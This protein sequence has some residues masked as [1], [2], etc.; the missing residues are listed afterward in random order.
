MPIDRSDSR[1]RPETPSADPEAPP[2]P[3]GITRRKFMTTVGAGAAATAV[4]GTLTAAP[5]E[6]RILRAGELVRVPLRVN[7]R[8]YRVLAEP[9]WS[10]MGRAISTAASARQP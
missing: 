9:R 7:G 6:T 4:A 10:L 1:P 5:Q 2:A 8:L 3:E